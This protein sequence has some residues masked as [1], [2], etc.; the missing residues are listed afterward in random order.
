MT[1]LSKTYARQYLE[2]VR[3]CGGAVTATSFDEDFEPVGHQVRTDLIAGG[4]IAQRG[5]VITLTEA[6]E[7]A[8]VDGS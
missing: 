7:M 2:Y 5:N 1:K 3:N 6:G 4:M 8:L